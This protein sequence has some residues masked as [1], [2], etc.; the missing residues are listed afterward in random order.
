MEVS[1]AH[2]RRRTKWALR[3]GYGSKR[4]E[5]AGEWRELQSEGTSNQGG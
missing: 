2:I 3:R 5:V 1:C 4:E